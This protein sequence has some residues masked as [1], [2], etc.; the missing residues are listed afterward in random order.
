MTIDLSIVMSVVDVR[1]SEMQVS[2]HCD[3]GLNSLDLRLNTSLV[4]DLN[5][6]I[7]VSPH[8]STRSP[9]LSGFNRTV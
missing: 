5:R 4:L 3:G 1:R 6:Q 9:D 7:Q 8:I 2:K